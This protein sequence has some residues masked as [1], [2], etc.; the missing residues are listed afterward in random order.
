VRAV[1]I[2]SWPQRHQ[3]F[4]NFDTPQP[5]LQITP[6]HFFLPARQP[7]TDS[8]PPRHPSSNEKEE[9]KEEE[10]EEEE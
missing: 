5:I 9:A 8:T 4:K 6:R 3:A 10:E 2:G 7:G 1:S